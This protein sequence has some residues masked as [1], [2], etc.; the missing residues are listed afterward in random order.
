MRF[1]GLLPIF[2]S[3]AFA[4]AQSWDELKAKRDRLNLHEEFDVSSVSKNTSTSQAHARHVALEFSEGRWREDTSGGAGHEIRIFDGSALFT[5]EE[6]GD[7]YKRQVPRKGWEP[8][9]FWPDDAEWSKVVERERHACG[10]P[11]TDHTCIQF[12]APL[13]KWSRQKGNDTIS[14]VDG[15]V[16]LLVDAETGAILAAHTVEALQNRRVAYQVDTRFTLKKLGYRDTAEAALFKVPP[17][18][19]EVKTLS[20]YDAT[21]AVKQM[22][23]QEAPTFTATAMD[24]KK[25]SLADFKGKTVLLDFWATWCPPCRADAPALDKLYKKYSDRLMI[26]GVS[27]G[28]ERAIVEKFLAK[29][30]HA[31]P[32]V[33]TSENDV[34]PPY[35]ISVLPTYIVIQADGTIASAAHGDQGFSD[36]RKLLKKSGLEVD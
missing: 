16:V 34:P 26:V 15:V 3:A 30:P 36:L 27:V 9:P 25:F 5:M 35:R 17:D 4:H 31:F 10:L 20:P 14:M 8:S 21:K 19:R 13:K 24:G 32:I 33:L 22:K 18:F 7:E 11:G 1:T 23:G 28:E 2:F 6:G 29:N 12:E